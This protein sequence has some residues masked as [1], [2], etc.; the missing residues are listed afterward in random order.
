MMKVCLALSAAMLLIAISTQ[1][2]ADDSIPVASTDDARAT[3]AANLKDID[4]FLEFI[5]DLYADLEAGKYGRIRL[6]DMDLI[7]TSRAT[8]RQVLT[9][10]SSID[11]LDRDERIAVYNA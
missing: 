8:L 1:S 2:L 11:E 7:T 6:S 3:V 10:K 4:T 5:E 9:G